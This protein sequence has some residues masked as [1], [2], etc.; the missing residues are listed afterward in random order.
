MKDAFEMLYRWTLTRKYKVRVIDLNKQNN[1]IKIIVDK[2]GK[3]ICLQLYLYSNTTE[4]Y[5]SV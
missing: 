4:H 2:D 3:N 1:R 5:I